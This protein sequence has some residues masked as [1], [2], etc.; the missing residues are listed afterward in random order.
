MSNHE[1]EYKTSQDGIKYPVL[2]APVELD[3]DVVDYTG[4]SELSPVNGFPVHHVY[5]SCSEI[6]EQGLPLDANPRE[7]SR[8]TPVKQMIETLT[9]NPGEFVKKNNGVVILAGDVEFDSNNESVSIDFESG[10]GVCNGG[11]TYFA[12]QTAED[13][14]DEATVHL[15]ILQIPTSLSGEER[16]DEVI[17]IARAR[18]TNNRLER[19]SEADFLG[20]Y[21]HFRSVIYNESSVQW[22]EGDSNAR[23]DAID[24]VHFI[25]LL[26]SMDALSYYHP[27]Y[28]PKANRHKSLATSRSRVHGDWLDQVEIAIEN[29]EP[30]PLHYLVPLVNDILKIRDYISH[31]LSKDDLGSFRHTKLFKEYISGAERDLHFGNFDGK[32]GMDL[33]DPMEVIFTGLFRSNT[34]LHNSSS[35]QKISLSGWYVNP[36]DLWDERKVNILS[37]MAEYYKEVESDPKKFIRVSA[38]FEKDLF[39]LGI[40]QDPPSPEIIYDTSNSDKYIKSDQEEDSPTHWLDESRVGGLISIDDEKPSYG[41]AVYKLEE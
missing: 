13:L 27:V 39:T 34:W 30:K 40:G 11:H 7:P 20:Y 32:K 26:K 28:N 25:R 3:L 10:D 15:E 36:Y 18:N 41:N 8:T 2:E 1:L 22:H 31:S 37:D 12:I 6:K 17:S 35:E 38:P 33:T 19:R 9:G 16:M 24:A 23:Y 4:V 21:D 29:E 5:V 14:K